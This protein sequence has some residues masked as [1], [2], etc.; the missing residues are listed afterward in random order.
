[1]L[2]RSL[3]GAG[4]Q[5]ACSNS[6]FARCSNSS[7]EE[8]LQ[9]TLS[10]R[11]ALSCHGSLQTAGDWSRFFKCLTCAHTILTGLVLSLREK[12]GK[13]ERRALT[14]LGSRYWGTVGSGAFGTHQRVTLAR[15]PQLLPQSFACL[16]RVQRKRK[17]RGKEGGGESSETSPCVCLQMLR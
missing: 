10:V 16:Q 7:N 3:D 11:T 8:P 9:Q 17:E 4:A 13:E 15:V 6:L 12:E 2:H 1:M 14:C 5:I